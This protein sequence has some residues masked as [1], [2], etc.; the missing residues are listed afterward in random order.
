M[1]NYWLI[2][3]KKNIHTAKILHFMFLITGQKKIG[4]VKL[5]ENALKRN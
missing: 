4:S 5:N 2:A 3:L 1:V